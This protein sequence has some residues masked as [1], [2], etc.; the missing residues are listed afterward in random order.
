MN[1]KKLQFCEC[2]TT[3]ERLSLQDA[4]LYGHSKLDDINRDIEQ[5]L[6]TGNIPKDIYNNIK[7]DNTRKINIFIELRSKIENTPRCKS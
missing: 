2:L 5:L 6:V 1:S 7:K 3:D 4:I